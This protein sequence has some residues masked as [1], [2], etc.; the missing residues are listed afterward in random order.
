MFFLNLRVHCGESSHCFLLNYSLHCRAQPQPSTKVI[1]PGTSSTSAAS[2]EQL[3]AGKITV[4][5]VF[6]R[7][8][9]INI[10]PG[11]LLINFDTKYN[12]RKN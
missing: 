8:D 1:P 4:K 3:I 10:R 7:F 9:Q 11:T 2:T 12:H 6:I 5:A